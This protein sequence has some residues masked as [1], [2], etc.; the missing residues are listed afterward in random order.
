MGEFP[1]T[2]TKSFKAEKGTDIAELDGWFYV[3]TDEVI[4]EQYPEIECSEVSLTLEL[5]EQLK[6]VSRA[7]QLINIELQ[8][9]LRDKYSLNDE[10]YFARIGVGKALGLY[11]FEPGEEEALKEFGL[12]VE[13]LRQ[14]ARLQKELIGLL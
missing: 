10:Q 6:L 13:K 12:F 3:H 4:P 1:N 14:E 8:N 5:K 7:Y 2:S 9:K 11:T